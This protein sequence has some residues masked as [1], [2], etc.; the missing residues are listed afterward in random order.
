MKDK[1]N[2]GDYQDKTRTDN[3]IRRMQVMYLVNSMHPFS[4]ASRLR[5]D[6]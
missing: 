1:N 4:P 5:P 2:S 3:Q 6:S